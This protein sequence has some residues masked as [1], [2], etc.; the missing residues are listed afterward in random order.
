MKK[1]IL[2][3]LALVLATGLALPMAK[4]AAAAT[5][6]QTTLYAGKN[7]PVGTVT[8]S[9]DADFLYVTYETTGG[10]KL[11][12]THLAVADSVEGIPQTKKG[13]PKVGNFP[14]KAKHKK[15]EEY[16]YKIEL[17][18]PSCTQLYIAAHAV[19]V[20]GKKEE[21]AWGYGEPCWG[22]RI[23]T[24]DKGGNWATY[25]KYKILAY[26]V[27]KCLSF[28]GTDDFVYNA[29]PNLDGMSAFSLEFWLKVND[30]STQQRI[31]FRSN[32]FTMWLAE[33]GATG[34]ISTET[35]GLSDEWEKWTAGIQTDT[36]HY[37]AFTYD[38]SYKRL[39]VDGSLVGSPV[40]CTGSFDAGIYSWVFSVFSY[41]LN[42]LLDEARV[43]S[44]ARS[45]AETSA[46]WNGG[47]GKKL[48]VD[49]N[50][51]ALWHFDEGGCTT[52]Y[53][54]TANHYD[55]TI[56]GASWADGFAF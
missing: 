21:T 40:A 14:Y 37:V 55:L 3:V 53:D 35:Y 1:I 12:E 10:W 36:W 51:L 46:N 5:V 15:V 19:V 33:G 29:G 54:E 49:A 43:S 52:A 44:I 39:Y 17:T 2:P 45:S 8:V 18:W 50:T 23:T 48:E 32:Q 11:K 42:G 30:N 24:R 20:N 31:A 25:F 56:I 47:S 22:R 4:P 27:N 34:C 9:N 13:N 38:G 41:T 26:G 6:T 16:T 7:I 28:D